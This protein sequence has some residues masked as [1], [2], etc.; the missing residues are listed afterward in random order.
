M[1]SRLCS[2]MCSP[3]YPIGGVDAVMGLFCGNSVIVRAVPNI[4]GSSS[5]QKSLKISSY[6]LVTGRIL[7]AA[8]VT[9]I[10]YSPGTKIFDALKDCTSVDSTKNTDAVVVLYGSGCVMAV[11]CPKS[12][13]L[14]RSGWIFGRVTSWFCSQTKFMGR[15]LFIFT[16]CPVSSFW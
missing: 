9:F 6:H 13:C 3:F 2:E 12:Q 14:K 1:V 11:M 8:N 15:K 7:V 10:L 16:Y 5:D 4:V